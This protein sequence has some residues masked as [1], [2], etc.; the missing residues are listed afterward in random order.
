W[1]ELV[2]RDDIDLISIAAPGLLHREITLEAA[3]NSKHI[4]CEKPLANN[5]QDAEE[6]VLAIE[7]AGVRHCCGY[8]YRQTPALAMAKRLF[9]EGKIG[10]VYNVHVRYAQDWQREPSFP[11][12]WRHDKKLAGSGALGDICAHS[13]DAVRFVTGMEIVRLVGQLK[14]MIPV[15]PLEDTKPNGE[16]GNVTVDDV[17]QFL[18]E[19]DTGATGCFEASRLAS[20]RRNHNSLEINGDKGSVY[21]T[22]EEQNYLYYFDNTNPVTEQGFRKIN[23]THDEHPYGG[24]Y[25]PQGHG[26]GYADMFVNQ[27][28][29]FLTAIVENKDFHPDFYD[30]LKVQ[31][32]LD[33]VE[34]SAQENRW[35]EL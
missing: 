9:D 30:G 22:F 3:K 23:C 8:T 5:L 2:R 12:V 25:W 34:R 16:K 20:G 32:V 17:A 4:L 13:I 21:W 35:V 28:R 15:R 24:G 11:F 14:T 6:M 26:I 29:L 19:F 1:R 33:A 31:Q 7:K 10:R 18:C 27:M